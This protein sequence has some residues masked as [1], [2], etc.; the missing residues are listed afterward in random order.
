MFCLIS[1]DGRHRVGDS[2]ITFHVVYKEEVKGWTYAIS[3]DAAREYLMRLVSDY[4]NQE[5]IEW[6]PFEVVTSR[7]IKPHKPADDEIDEA[8]REIFHTHL[9]DAFAD[10]ESFLIR[11]ANPIIPDD[12]FDKVRERFQIFFNFLLTQS[13]QDAKVGS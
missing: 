9:R 8:K 6:L 4:L 1:D 2:K 12:A 5:K 11:L 13:R 10:E 3:E 7:S